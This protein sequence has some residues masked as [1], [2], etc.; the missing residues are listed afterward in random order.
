MVEHFI[1]RGDR[2]ADGGRHEDRSLRVC[3]RRVQRWRRWRGL[4]KCTHPGTSH[5]RGDYKCVVFTK[6]H[7]QLG[8]GGSLQWVG[9]SKRSRVSGVKWLSISSDVAPALSAYRLRDSCGRC[10]SFK[11]LRL[12]DRPFEAGVSAV[13][14]PVQRVEQTIAK[15][16]RFPSSFSVTNGWTGTTFKTTVCLRSVVVLCGLTMPTTRHLYTVPT[17]FE[18]CE[19]MRLYGWT[20]VRT[21]LSV[22]PHV[23]QSRKVTNGWT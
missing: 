1:R 20:S 17:D 7:E 2:V 8:G 22:C 12:C 23:R 14:E 15:L 11:A 21:R 4:R 3:H 19:A 10:G 13:S 16:C 6:W 18:R 9:A 5:A